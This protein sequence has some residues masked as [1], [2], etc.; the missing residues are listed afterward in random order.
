MRIKNLDAWWFANTQKMEDIL[1]PDWFS[2]RTHI[3]IYA[4]YEGQFILPLLI[5]IRAKT[6]D[7]TTLS[8]MKYYIEDFEDTEEYDIFIKET[9]F[10]FKG[11]IT[12]TQNLPDELEVILQNEKST[13]KEN[14]SLSYVE[15]SGKITDFSNRPFPAPF[16]LQR[17][18]FGGK[19]AYIGAWS[20]NL[21]EYKIK[22]P[23]GTY[24]SF[25]VD[26]NSYGVSSL[27]CW[28]WNMLVDK[29]EIHNFK[30]GNGEVY[31]LK[32]F[33]DKADDTSLWCDFRPM[34]LPCIRKEEYEININDK[35]Y[36][37]INCQP[38]IKQN[39]LAIYID[40]K[41]VDVTSLETKYEIIQNNN[42]NYALIRYLIKVKNP[43]K[44]KDKQLVILEYQTTGKYKA[45]AQGRT[46]LLHTD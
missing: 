25:Y 31:D 2:P 3:A 15:L 17:K 4:K 35:K 46:Q 43:N 8:E 42:I 6:K 45:Y 20:N 9:E 5:F 36:F 13:Y 30:I 26:D 29:N 14:I 33:K 38:D 44:V 16:I 40:G 24:Q 28:G 41:K 10:L 22:V 27:E 34:V 37:L 23:T 39:E 32:V 1:Q 12:E 11:F 19:R 7:G 18:L 21:G